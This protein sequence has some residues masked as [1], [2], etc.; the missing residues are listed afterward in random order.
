MKVFEHH[1]MRLFNTFGINVEARYFVVFEHVSDIAEF[2]GETRFAGLP[3]LILGGGSNVLFRQDYPG[4]ILHIGFKGIELLDDSGEDVIIRAAAGE[5]WHDFVRATIEWGYAGLENL[6]LIP[7][8]VGAAPIQNIGAYGVEL[9]EVF[10][11]LEAVDLETG[12]AKTF[13][14][15]AAQFDYRDSYFK[16][17]TPGQWLVTSVT[18]R[19]PKQPSWHVEYQGLRDKLSTDDQPL[20]AQSISDAVCQVRRAKLPDPMELGNSGSFFKNPMVSDIDYQLL[21]KQSPNLPG[22][23][24]PNG[25]Y[26]LSA[27]WLIECCGWKGYR[28]GDAGV[29]NMHALVLVNHGKATGEAIWQLAERIMVSVQER[30]G[31]ALKPE[32]RIL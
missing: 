3:K 1:S 11:S 13:N 30:F 27:A 24:Q 10:Y 6:S 16:S 5:N 4:V 19:L 17:V 2:M 7:G 12:I 8:T 15:A 18:V 25:T 14:H 22:F 9:R 28:E 23:E 21:K 29:S 20:S 31:V 26:K 32:P